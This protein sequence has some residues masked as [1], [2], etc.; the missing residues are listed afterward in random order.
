VDDPLVQLP[1]SQALAQRFGH[2]LHELDNP[3]PILSGLL[4]GRFARI[5]GRAG[6]PQRHHHGHSAQENTD[7]QS[8]KHGSIILRAETATRKG[9]VRQVSEATLNRA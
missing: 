1:P 6:P 9:E 2:E 7:D 8:K 4:P 3:L 5:G